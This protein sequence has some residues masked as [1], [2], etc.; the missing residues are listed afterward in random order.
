MEFVKRFKHK[1]SSDVFN[2]RNLKRQS[3]VT[4]CTKREGKEK[5]TASVAVSSY[6]KIAIEL[7]LGRLGRPKK[8][9]LLQECDDR[10]ANRRQLCEPEVENLGM[11]TLGDE[12]LA[13]LMSRWTIPSCDC[14]G[15]QAL[16]RAG[17]MQRVA[18]G[19]W[20][21]DSRGPK[22]HA[23]PLPFAEITQF[24]RNLGRRKIFVCG[25]A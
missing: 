3:V 2:L 13:G 12:N 8:L 17:A 25:H 23:A 19:S 9:A 5:E 10:A 14:S 21:S 16:R 6:C 11:S 24:M 22:G 18:K 20:P 15:Q 7:R 4:R 1:R